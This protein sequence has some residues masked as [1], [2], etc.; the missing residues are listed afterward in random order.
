M[1]SFGQRGSGSSGSPLRPTLTR[2]VDHRRGIEL[3]SSA[4]P[5]GSTITELVEQL[6]VR[7]LAAAETAQAEEFVGRVE[8]LIIQAEGEADCVHAQV[9]QQDGADRYAAAGA[10][11]V[12]L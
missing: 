7:R 11:E 10:D 8:L 5:S 4:S 6:A 1:E 9:L 2:T 3:S 12:R